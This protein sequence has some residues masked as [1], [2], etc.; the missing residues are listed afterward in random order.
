MCVDLDGV[1]KEQQAVWG[2]INQIRDK[3]SGLDAEIKSLQDDLTA[4]MQKRD[5]A[6]DN[7]K[8]LRQQRDEG[9]YFFYVND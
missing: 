5:K 8:S 9:V 3:V 6:Y 1:R 7:I 2:R 4:V